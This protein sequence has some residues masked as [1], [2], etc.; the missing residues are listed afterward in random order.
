MLFHDR[1]TIEGPARITRD[2]YFVAD[3]LVAQADNIQDYRP[4]EVKQPPKAD[5]TPYRIGRRAEDVFADEAM[6]SAAH[7]PITIGHPKEDVTSANWRRLAVGD[8]GGDVAQQGKFLRVPLK[9]MDADGIRAVRT[10]HQEISLGYTADIDMT[11]QK[12][13]D[14]QVDGVMR[15]IRVNHV[16]FVP[17]ARGGSKLRI[18][19][20]RP[21]HLRD[22]FTQEKP[23]MKI[24]I[25]DAKDVDLSDG[26]AVA[27][28]VGALNTTLSDAQAKVGTLTAEATTLKDAND[29][30]T[31]ENAALKT[32]V[33]DAAITPQ[34]LH[35]LADARAKVIT[36]AKKIGGE[37]LITDGKTDAEIRKL[38]VT[39]KLGDAA[40]T[41]PDAAIEGAFAALAVSDAKP[42]TFRTTVTDHSVS[43]GDGAWN[44]N[45]F[46]SA[47][48]A[49]KKVS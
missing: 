21:A 4:D 15:N 29:K 39:A 24:T 8:V 20:E 42:D 16:A 23:T 44:D 31:G 25:G 45:V 28:A 34:K 17:A 37:A 2:G 11:P 3:A 27:L 22:D 36:D 40:A 19:D 12:I 5:G 48:V 6:A 32:Q 9:L 38:A 46:K 41:M 10:T 1:A 26:A 33:A 14:E 49:V 43:L 35:A 30:L 13:G 47:G 7:R 18:V